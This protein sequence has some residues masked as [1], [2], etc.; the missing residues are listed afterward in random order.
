MALIH[1]F[2]YV[3]NRRTGVPMAGVI[4]SALYKGT[5]TVAPIYADEDQ[6]PLIPENQATTDADGNYSFYI[7]QGQYSLLY[8]V[9]SSV[10]KT[11]ED[12]TPGLSGPSGPANSTY[13][14]T[15]DLEVSA[16]SNVSAIL[17]E[18][19]KAGT[20]TIRDYADF[21]AEVAADTGKVNYIRSTSST[22]KVWVRTSILSQ[23]ADQIGTAAGVSVEAA[24]AT[25]ATINDEGVLVGAEAANIASSGTNT[26]FIRPSVNVTDG[27]LFKSATTNFATP[28]PVEIDGSIVQ[29]TVSEAFRIR[30][31]PNS[32]ALGVDILQSSPSSGTQ[33]GPF[34][35]NV[36][37]ATIRSALT[38]GGIPGNPGSGTW[39]GFQC[40]VNAGGVNYDGDS[41]MGGSFGVVQT[42]AD[43]SLGDKNGLSSGVVIDAFTLGKGYGGSSGA[44]VGPDGSCPAM[45]GYETDVIIESPNVDHVVGFNSWAGGSEQ[46]IYTHA[47]YTI[48]AAGGMGQ[49]GNGVAGW[50]TGFRLFTQGGLTNSPMDPTGSLF[51]SDHEAAL[52]NIFNYEN[53]TVSGHILKFD[54]VKLTGL[55]QLSLPHAS[56]G[57]GI[58]DVYDEDAWLSLAPPSTGKY[59][60]FISGGAAPTDIR[61][62]GFW[63][64]SSDGHLHFRDGS[65]NHFRLVREAV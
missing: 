21:T 2:D 60:L 3:E 14:T 47:A 36:I 55:G 45:V 1:V 43:T 12:F 44:T 20:F 16:T 62:W 15:A 26:L 38:T 54:N 33:S 6:T 27:T 10:I 39:A 46:G 32:A 50:L 23:A 59:S 8:S 40:S 64:D 57:I 29:A 28:K 49:N 5:Q 9:G 58:G 13:S 7:E 41:V 52:A 19:G 61:A 37:E 31:T 42:L 22:D 30:P 65:G 18:A 35:F 56:A 4:V 48:G 24:L 25:K 11:V 63:M 17:S 53:V 34:Y 51:D